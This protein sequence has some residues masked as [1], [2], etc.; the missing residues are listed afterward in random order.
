MIN[1]HGATPH[2]FRHTY[3]TLAASTGM[4]V[5]TLQEIAGHSDIG[6]TMNRYAH[7]RTEKVVEAGRLIHGVFSPCD[8]PLT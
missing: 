6:T 2:I 5:K 1:L 7:A 8:K 4:D 3:I